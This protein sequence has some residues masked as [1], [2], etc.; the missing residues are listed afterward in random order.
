MRRCGMEQLLSGRGFSEGF[1]YAEP[2]MVPLV[3]VYCI[4]DHLMYICLQ[5][6]AMAELNELDI[7]KYC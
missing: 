3:E 4:D 6:T 5:F 7:Y 2:Q 1:I